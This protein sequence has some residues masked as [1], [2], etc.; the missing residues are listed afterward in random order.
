[1]PLKIMSYLLL[2]FLLSCQKPADSQRDKIIPSSIASTEEQT[3]VQATISEIQNLATSAGISYSFINF[4][5]VV[6][7]QSADGSQPLAFCHKDRNGKG[8]YIGI[9]KKTLDGIN[10]SSISEN[11]LFLLL[12]HEFGHCLFDRSHEDVVLS[13]STVKIYLVDQV[14]QNRS[15]FRNQI[16]ASAMNESTPGTIG[17]YY[18]SEAIKK[19]YISEVAGISRWKTVFDLGGIDGIRLV[20]E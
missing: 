17:S 8:I 10:E 14:G 3:L 6:V 18:L 20:I 2:G 9:L 19:Y 1:M 7:K 16:P 4:P 5:V 12:V 11:Y 13:H 15:P